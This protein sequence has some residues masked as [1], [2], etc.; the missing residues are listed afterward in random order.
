MALVPVSTSRIA[1]DATTGEAGDRPADR[2]YG[3]TPDDVSSR[4]ISLIIYDSSFHY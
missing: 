4:N 3:R 2:N 1:N